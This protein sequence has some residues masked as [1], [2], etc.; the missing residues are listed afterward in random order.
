MKIY[1]ITPKILSCWACPIAIFCQIH[2][3]RGQ[4]YVACCLGL[5]KQGPLNIFK[6]DLY[7]VFLRMHTYFASWLCTSG[8]SCWGSPT[9]MKRRAEKSGPRQVGC[10]TWDAS[11]TIQTSKLR[12]LNRGWDI[13]RHVLATIDWEKT[14]ELGLNDTQWNRTWDASSTIQTSN[15]RWLNRGCAIPRHV[16]A[17][18]DYKWHTISIFRWLVNNTNIEAA[19]AEQRVGHAKTHAGHA[20]LRENERIEIIFKYL[21]P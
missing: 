12:W 10:S 16:L 1:Q 2:L 9:R 13:P 15:P 21:S 3:Q 8:G 18:I 17:T 20:R 5:R 19:L 6:D 4:C 14:R 7:D 11:S